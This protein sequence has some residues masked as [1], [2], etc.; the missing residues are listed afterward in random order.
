M[1]AAMITNAEMEAFADFL[2]AWLE[3]DLK[4]G[5][6]KTKPQTDEPGVSPQSTSKTGFRWLAEPVP[7]IKDC[8]EGQHG[9]RR[10]RSCGLFGGRY[11]I[12]K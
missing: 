3:R 2:G 8:P 6:L 4:A 12:S 9:Y 5:L 7:L 11:I 10:G 1:G